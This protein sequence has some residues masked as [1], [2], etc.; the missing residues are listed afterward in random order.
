MLLQHKD[1]LPLTS[2]RIAAIFLLHEFY[3]SEQSSSGNP[4]SQFFVELLQ[5]HVEDNRTVAGMTCG[6]S[7]S[8]IEKWFLAHLLSS[9]TP[10]DVGYIIIVVT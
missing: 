7:L 3:R 10:K 8:H 1:L 6:H 5:P 4:F 2:Q 9:L